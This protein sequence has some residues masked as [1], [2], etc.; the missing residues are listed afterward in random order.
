MCGTI[1]RSSMS[2]EQFNQRSDESM[3]F[4]H[5]RRGVPGP[6]RE[7]RYIGGLKVSYDMSL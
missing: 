5:L 2:G 3:A 4:E 6:W 1:H 7:G